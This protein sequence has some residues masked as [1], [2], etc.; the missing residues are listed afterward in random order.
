MYRKE[1][2][3][4][5]PPESFELPF[6]GK[7]SEDNRWVIMAS[8]I[9]WS[10]FEEEY[11]T[12]FSE[13]MGA[14]AKSFR[15]A[16]GALIIKEKLGISDRET[17]EQIKENPYLQYFIGMSSYR[18]ESPFDASMLVHFRERISAELISKVNQQ[19]VRPLGG[20]GF[21]P[22]K[23]A[24]PKGKE[25]ARD[26]IFSMG[27]KKTVEAEKEGEIPKNQGK[28]I[29][30]A[31]CAPSDISYPTDL[32]ILNQARKQ[33]EKIIDLLYE[34]IKGQLEKK[35]RT[36]REVARKDYLEVAKKRRVSQK[37]RRKAMKKQLQY[38]K[39]N[40]SHI[41]QLII[42]GASLERLSTR[43]YKMLLV[44]AEV[45]RQQL[46]LYENKKQSIDDRRRE[47]NSTTY[48]SNYSRESW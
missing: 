39:R 24:N 12:F 44:V 30:D 25:D 43:Q 34:Q 35:P 26:N 10:E 48:P 40:L 23:V 22:A 37:D 45:Y 18:N 4:Q 32:E 11:A 36:Y 2:P 14:P 20:V 19:M 46:W 28:L 47:F 27:W 38:I 15:M 16:L 21:R 42:L 6:E 9:P 7:L 29:I 41:E 5:I 13:E 17:V 8:L 31:T 33:A 3:T 1:E